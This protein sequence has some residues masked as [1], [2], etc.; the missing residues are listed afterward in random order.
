MQQMQQYCNKTTNATN[1]TV[2]MA[3]LQS[4]VES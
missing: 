4:D 3:A 2:M 1:A